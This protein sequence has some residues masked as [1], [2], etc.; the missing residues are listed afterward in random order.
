MDAVDTHG[1]TPLHYATDAQSQTAALVNVFAE[2]PKGKVPVLTLRSSPPISMASDHAQNV[3]VSRLEKAQLKTVQLLLAFGANPNAHVAVTGSTPLHLAA[4]SGATAVVE[5]LLK[6]GAEIESRNRHGAT[7]LIVASVAG[8]TSTCSTLIKAGARVDARDARARNAAWY[9]RASASAMEPKDILRLFGTV[10]SNP[11]R[12][13]RTV[14]IGHSGGWGTK[15]NQS[16]IIREDFDICDVDQRD[17]RMSA[18]VFESDY[19]HANRPLLLVNATLDMPASRSWTR[20]NFF[21][22]V[23]GQV[24]GPQKLPVRKGAW[25]PKSK[26]GQDISLSDYFD[27][28]ERG[29]Y[30]KKLCWNNPRNDTVWHLLK[31]DLAWPDALLTPTTKRSTRSSGTFGLFVGPQGSGISMHHHKAT[32]NALLFGRKLWILTPPPQSTFHRDELAEHSFS[33]A[34]HG[35]LNEALTRKQTSKESMSQRNGRLYVVQH[36]GDILFVPAGWGHST[37]NLQESVG[38]ANFF[39]DEDAAGYR[40]AKIFHSNRG[41]RSLQTAAG[42]SAPSDMHADGH[43]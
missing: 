2:P 18:A 26:G 8:H 34:G 36:S 19:L 42:I 38:V 11:Q 40:P 13:T 20:S 25:L 16:A 32:W 5:L 7:P 1:R 15:D 37:L 24:F 4:R 22:K 39:L 3:V 43:P 29:Q 21:K 27:G 30:A 35:W 33:N 14:D 28:V 41:I 23:Q 10:K 31:Q 6:H 9:A 17:H 12:I